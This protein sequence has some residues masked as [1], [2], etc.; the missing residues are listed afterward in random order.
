VHVVLSMDVGGLERVVLDLVREG[1][2]IGQQPSVV[3]IERPGTL[4]PQVEAMGAAVYCVNKAPGLRPGLLRPLKKLFGQVRPDVVHTH[5]IGALL[6]AGPAARRVGVPVVVHTEHGKHFGTFRRRL[7][8]RL[9]GTYARRCFCVSRDIAAEVERGGVFPAAK[10]RELPNGIDTSKFAWLT[11][12]DAAEARASLSIPAAAP[13]VGT[14]GRLNPVK[15]QDVLIRGFADLAHRLPEARLV[16]VGDGPLLSELR[17]LAAELRVGDKVHFAGYQS[18]PERFMAAMDVFALTSESEGM[19]LSVLEAWAAGLPV[20]GSRVGGLPQLIE[21]GATG[22]LFP[23]PDHLA[24]ANVLFELL[25][26][27]DRARA[28]GAAG[29]ERVDSLFSARRMTTDYAAHYAD[30]L[31]ARA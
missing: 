9:A 23:F 13:L 5:Q 10:I 17:D 25:T 3:C 21:E 19:P 8:G 15:R 18:Q 6:Y 11:D 2:A 1:K 20:V 4:A 14:V 27:R 22:H 31:A 26:H 28:M 16:L 30:I 7:L 24:L 12:A 29:R